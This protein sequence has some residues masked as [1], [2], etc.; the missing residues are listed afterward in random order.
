MEKK[1]FLKTMLCSILV[2]SLISCSESEQELEPTLKSALEVELATEVIVATLENDLEAGD[3]LWREHG[4]LTGS[5][6]EYKD[7]NLTMWVDQDGSVGFD[8]IER[9][10]EAGGIVISLDNYDDLVGMTFEVELELPAAYPQFSAGVGV[11]QTFGIFEKNP[12]RPQLMRG[13]FVNFGYCPGYEQFQ[14]ISRRRHSRRESHVPLGGHHFYFGGADEVFMK[15]HQVD[16]G[17]GPLDK[18]LNRVIASIKLEI[19]TNSI[20]FSANGEEPYYVQ[21]TQPG[22]LLGEE[23]ELRI[24]T[25][26]ANVKFGSYDPAGAPYVTFVNSL[27]IDEE[28][29]L[30]SS[31]K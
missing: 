16:M 5:N 12:K 2:S 22:Y 14:K 21:E 18:D 28:E 9:E 23:F 27:K 20:E 10:T 19:K 30:L 8:G 1:I 26:A 17:F 24:M 13:A 11:A 29:I 6:V 25:H 15:D 3:F 7:G 31:L 4:Y